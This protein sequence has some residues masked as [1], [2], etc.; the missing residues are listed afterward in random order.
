MIFLHF[1]L[2]LRFQNPTGEN[3][4]IPKISD[5]SFQQTLR[6]YNRSVIVFQDNPYLLEFMNYGIFKYKSEI[7]FAQADF[8][9]SKMYI[10]CQEEPCIIPFEY[11]KQIFTEPYPLSQFGF[12]T[13]LE[14]ILTPG[15]IAIKTIDHFQKF[16]DSDESRL[17]GV[18]IEERPSIPTNI[19]F[20]TVSSS[21]LNRL[22]LSGLEKGLYVYRKNE[23]QFIPYSEGN[24]ETQ[25]KSSFIDAERLENEKL[26]KFLCGLIISPDY[27]ANNELEAL[28]KII[29]KHQDKVSFLLGSEKKAAAVISEA[30]LKKAKAPYFFVVESE[31]FSKSKWLVTDGSD[32][33]SEYLDTFLTNIEKGKEPVSY[34]SAT[35]HNSP[36]STFKEI[37][38]KMYYD[39]IS[40]KENDVLLVIT[41]PWC[42]HCKDF[43]PVL[44]VTSRLL[45]E[46]KIHAK[47]Y[48][49]DGTANDLPDD[50]PQYT[51][52]PTLFMFTTKNKT[53]ITFDGDRTISGLLDFLHTDGSIKF[54]DPVY[55]QKQT[56]E[57]IEK[58]RDEQHSS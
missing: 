8:A 45:N 19:L 20:Y 12:A 6:S 11:D 41:A 39:I 27:D 24:I 44:N 58:L 47:F 38:R 46:N 15:V 25:S 23:R 3:L 2:S 18:D 52:F 36:D 14:N 49:I 42:H 13:W 1:L 57:E 31:N 34:I 30:K 33:N 26:K 4:Y 32:F 22:H 55:D 29:P 50:F 35:V 48:W 40:D 9:L 28:Q 37:N 56:D 53:A 16:L 17:I 7:L 21:F 54:T 5:K 43:K 51:G 10:G